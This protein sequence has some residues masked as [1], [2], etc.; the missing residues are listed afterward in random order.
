M[1]FME[2]FKRA[3][4]ISV[5][6]EMKQNTGVER[7]NVFVYLFWKLILFVSNSFLLTAWEEGR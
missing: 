2:G 4:T 6:V 7:Q 3:T 1:I 5:V